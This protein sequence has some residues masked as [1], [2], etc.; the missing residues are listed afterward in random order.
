MPD[1]YDMK[2]SVL[3]NLY[4]D[5]RL[6]ERMVHVE[7]SDGCV[8]LS[9]TAPRYGARM[10]AEEDAYAVPGVSSVKNEMI[11]SYA[12]GEILPTDRE[13]ADDVEK[14]LSLEPDLADLPV[15]VSVSGAVV[16]VEG[17]VEG[18]SQK[19]KI[20]DIVGTTMGVMGIVNKLGVALTENVA[21]RSIS[22]AIIELIYDQTDIDI[23]LLDVEVRNGV[24]R[25]S[26]R[27]PNRDSER[28]I[29][30]LIRRVSGIIEIKN[31]L[32]RK[33]FI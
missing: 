28:E 1:D 32:Q 22:E 6:D 5:D 29:L 2:N 4:E 21:D 9:G 33:P 10:A 17:T 20:E 15:R 31:D 14:T 16:I 12:P 11:V 18:Y 24:V 19:R 27:I 26:G 3:D 25:L 23:D 7:V 30:D 13:I 8:R